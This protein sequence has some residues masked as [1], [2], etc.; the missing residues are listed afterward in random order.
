M[1]PPAFRLTIHAY[2]GKPFVALLRRHAKA[3]RALLPR[4]LHDVSIVLVN[5]HKMSDLHLR[6][7]NITGPTDVLTFPMDESS[8]EIVICV[9]E[10]KRRAKEHR[11]TLQNELLLYAVHGMLHLCG[12]DDRTQKGFDAM[13]RME[14]RILTKI[15]VGAV[16]DSSQEACWLKPA[17]RRAG[18]SPHEPKRPRT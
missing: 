13:H 1:R 5:D 15:G 7:M 17:R 12:M 10:A 9:P 14:D 2:T 4:D 18:F 16:F 8:G 6:F 3:A 11:T